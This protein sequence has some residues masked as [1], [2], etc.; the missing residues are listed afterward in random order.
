MNTVNA[1][2]EAEGTENFD[3]AHLFGLAVEHGEAIWQEE[4]ALRYQRGRG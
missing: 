3:V 4:L 2:S 1:T